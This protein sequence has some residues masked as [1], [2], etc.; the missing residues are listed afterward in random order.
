[1]I[2]KMDLKEL[3]SVDPECHWYY[4]FKSESLIKNSK[5]K[6]GN[7]SII[8][9]IGAGSAFFLK[10]ASTLFPN[11]DCIAVDPFYD[12]SN[13]PRYENLTY[14][15]TIPEKQADLV[16]LIDVL[17]HVDNDLELLT[18]AAKSSKQGSKHVIS[19]PA[20]KFLWSG[21]DDFLGHKR[22]YRVNELTK[23]AGDAGLQV[24][25][26]GY[27]FGGIFPGVVVFR[28]TKKFFR[29]SNGESSDLRKNSNF[30]NSILGHFLRL[31]GPI[32]RNKYFGLSA[33]VI[34]TKI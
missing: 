28:L 3:G 14:S 10:E 11:A 4:K 9:E 25:D 7:P 17:E 13:F 23:L 33:F 20:F 19:V 2:L 31:S 21:H 6:F 24:E 30:I 1:V 5:D 8:V 18:T 27:L 15:L 22:R 26:Y 29:K 16:F 34:A 32:S 12:Q